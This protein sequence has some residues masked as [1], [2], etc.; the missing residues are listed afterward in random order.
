MSSEA[1]ITP[2]VLICIRDLTWCAYKCRFLAA[3]DV[4]DMEE[5]EGV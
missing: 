2:S 3:A 4:D 1:T 5:E